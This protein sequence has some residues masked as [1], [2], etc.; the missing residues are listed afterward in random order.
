VDES[1]VE[2]FEEVE[3]MQA[4]SSKGKKGKKLREQV[5]IE[6]QQRL[7]RALRELKRA[8]NALIAS[9]GK[10]RLDRAFTAPSQRLNRALREP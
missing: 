10:K 6:P 2:F 4:L 1:A 9:K 7:N 8:H 5:L 3:M